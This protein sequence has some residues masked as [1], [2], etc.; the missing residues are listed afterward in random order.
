MAGIENRKIKVIKGG[1]KSEDSEPKFGAKKVNPSDWVKESLA[2][3]EAENN[4]RNEKFYG[5]RT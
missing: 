2:N 4:I 5:K 3:I 1:I